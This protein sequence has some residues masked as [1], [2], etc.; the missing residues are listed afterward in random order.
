MIDPD[1]YEADPTVQPKPVPVDQRPA[2]V[3]V[4]HDT[5]DDRQ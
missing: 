5:E 1:P 3:P 4:D 2:T